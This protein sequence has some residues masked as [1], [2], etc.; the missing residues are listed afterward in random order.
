M[1]R[2]LRYLIHILLFVGFIFVFDRSLFYLV[3]SLQRGLSQKESFRNRFISFPKGTYDIL[4]M[5]SSRAFRG[6]H[7]LYFYRQMG[8]NAFKVARH[9][10]GPKFNY[11]FYQQFKR[12]AGKPRMV[13][14]GVDYFMFGLRSPEWFM[15]Y[16]DGD[17]YMRDHFD[18]GPL[19]LLSNKAQIDSF[20]TN[21][22][23]GIG[24]AAGRSPA[25]RRTGVVKIVDD[26][27][28]FPAKKQLNTEKPA[29]Y[30]KIPYSPFPGREGE[31]F[32]K[33][34]RDLD[35]DGV[36]VVL[37]VLPDYIGTYETNFQR[38]R[39]LSDIH[40]VTRDFEM[41]HLFN[42]NSPEKFPLRDPRHFLDG[43]YGF[44]NSHL[45]KRGGRVLN[46]MLID[47]IKKLREGYGGDQ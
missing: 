3:Q 4:I 11:F 12:H 16:L 9:A 21:W 23:T 38:E 19:L 31:Y 33:L 2:P 45:S 27:V 36:T 22:L 5:G 10:A 32:L 6:I 15:R 25:S 37:V 44:G 17:E 41:I 40:D 18:G 8:E 20:M 39:F 13:V 43:G 47:D 35:R 24:P 34:L 29:R 42:Y 1:S 30:R 7:P 46:R 28:G 14:Y 26:F